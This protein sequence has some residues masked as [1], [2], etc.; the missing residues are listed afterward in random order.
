M[1]SGNATGPNHPIT[2]KNPLWLSMTCSMRSAGMRSAWPDCSIWL[3]M[4]SRGSTFCIHT[5]VNAMPR[6][7]QQTSGSQK[8]ASV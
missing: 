2:L 8:R 5:A 6:T 4:N 3:R 7:I 1:T